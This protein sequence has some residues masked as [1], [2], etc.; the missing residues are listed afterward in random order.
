MEISRKQEARALD[1]EEREMIAQTH[2]PALQAV[3][4]EAL[5][6][7]VARVRERRDRA[8]TL[9]KR[10]RREM[11]G[12]AAPRGAEAS[13]DD[14]G[15][16]LKADILAAAMRRL[17][18]EVARRERMQARIALVESQRRALAMASAAA[19]TPEPV[20]NTR[21]ARK[22]MAANPS[23]KP[24]PIGSRMEVGRVSQFVKVAQAR[25][26]AR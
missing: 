16:R 19:A 15:S 6:D 23:R 24:R 9:A 8:K 18:A 25:R 7:L 5:V 26:D 1:A 4:D 17:N 12:K 10:R 13:A 22:G 21:T 11:R 3:S 14:T 20:A 2:H